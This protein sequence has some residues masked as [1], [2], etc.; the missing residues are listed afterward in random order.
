MTDNEY[1]QQF[2]NLT[3]L[4]EEAKGGNNTALAKIILG[5]IEL[6]AGEIANKVLQEKIYVFS[7][8]DDQSQKYKP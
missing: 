3:A 8:E 5:A 7:E 4:I 2:E 6:I 1:K